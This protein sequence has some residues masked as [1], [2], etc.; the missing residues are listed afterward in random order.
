MQILTGGSG[1]QY[2]P[3]LWATGAL[4]MCSITWDHTSVPAKWHLFLSNGFSRVHECDI[5]TDL[6]TGSSVR[7]DSI[8]PF[9][10]VG[11]TGSG[12]ALLLGYF[13][14]PSGFITINHYYSIA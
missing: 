1:P 9:S 13:V 11:V 14:I 4:T 3:F 7:V 5:Q 2:L 10:I 6:T 12:P 8:V